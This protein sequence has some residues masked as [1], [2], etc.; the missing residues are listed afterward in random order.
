M[1]V[2]NALMAGRRTVASESSASFNNAGAA[3]LLIKRGADVNLADVDGVTPLMEAAGTGATEIV[4]MLLEHGADANLKDA[5]GR[6]AADIA[7]KKRKTQA[8]SLLKTAN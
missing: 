6:T 7:K 4:R 3:E 1:V 5:D 8:L 2:P